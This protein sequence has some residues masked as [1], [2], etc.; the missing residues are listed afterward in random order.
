M[1]AREIAMMR[2]RAALLI[3]ANMDADPES[4]S[5]SRADVDRI[6]EAIDQERISP[7][8]RDPIGKQ[9]LDDAY[10]IGVALFARIFEAEEEVQSPSVV[11]EPSKKGE[12]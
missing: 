8:G 12:A 5:R 9:E 2:T 6:D 7:R 1:T 3:A 10:K 4:R 11:W